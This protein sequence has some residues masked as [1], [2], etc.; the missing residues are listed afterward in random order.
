MIHRKQKQEMSKEN[1]HTVYTCLFITIASQWNLL[2]AS[3][4][5][6]YTTYSWHGELRSWSD[7]KGHSSNV[8]REPRGCT[9]VRYIFGIHQN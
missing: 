9:C 5:A 2:E 1:S 3:G 4:L 8:R 6:Q 7:R